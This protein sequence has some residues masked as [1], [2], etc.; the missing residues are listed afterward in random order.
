MQITSNTKPEVNTVEVEF[1]VAPEDF[2]DAVQSVFL[3]KRKNIT[4]PGF[5]KGKATRKMIEAQYGEGTFYEDAVNDLYRDSLPKIV[6]ELKLDIVDSP[7]VEVS[8]LSKETGV[9]FTAKFTVKPEVEINGYKGVEIEIEPVEVTDSDVNER[10]EKIRLENARIVNSSDRPVETGDTIKFDFTGFCDGEAFEGGTATDFELEIGSGRFI[11]GFEEQ[12]I[13]KNVG[14]DFDINVTFPE[15]YPA[16]AIKGKEAVFKCKIH[17]KT[18][19]ETFDLDDEFVKDISDLNTLDEFRDDIRKQISE[20]K[21]KIRDIE[22]EREIAD[23]ISEMVKSEIPQV[24]YED[25]INDMARDWAYRYQ[26][27]PEDFARQSGMT[28]EQYRE[29]FRQIAE[30]QVRFRLALEKIAELESFEV[31]KEELDAE[32]DKMSTENHVPAEKVR[33][34]ITVSALE[35]DIKSEKALKLLKESAMIK[36]KTIKK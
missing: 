9:T 3:R 16:D 22:L 35:S 1:N 33:E 15:D 32:Y 36:D 4:I 23:K 29:G 28:P 26:M 2:E 14:G 19:K 20:E 11:P 10:L 21:D 7:E 8:D 30:K 31:T 27:R 12:M 6:D 18:S 17:E 34:I 25:R 13:G 24:M 5:R